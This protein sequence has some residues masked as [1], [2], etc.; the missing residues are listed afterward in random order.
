M[1]TMLAATGW[2]ATFNGERGHTFRE[3]LMFWILEEGGPVGYVLS[4]RT[5]RPRSAECAAN[6]AGYV[7]DDDAD[8]TIVPAESGW[9]IVEHDGAGLD[10]AYWTKVLAWRISNDGYEVKA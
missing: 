7:R 3:P 1:S 10:R 9:W 6:F 2:K 5:G 8:A 4:E